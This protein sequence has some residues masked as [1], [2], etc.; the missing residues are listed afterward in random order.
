MKSEEKKKKNQPRDAVFLFY[1]FPAVFL[2]SFILRGSGR[3]ILT[4]GT[5]I[6]LLCLHFDNEDRDILEY[7]VIYNTV[8][9]VMCP[10][11]I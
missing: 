8:G 1:S 11:L 10:E 9:F 5:R 6:P 4:T 3:E 7:Q 2:P